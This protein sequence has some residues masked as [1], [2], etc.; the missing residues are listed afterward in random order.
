MAHSDEF[1]VFAHRGAGQVGRAPHRV[2][3]VFAPVIPQADLVLALRHCDDADL[4]AAKMPADADTP[5]YALVATYGAGGGDGQVAVFARGPV[6]IEADGPTGEVAFSVEAQR[7]AAYALPLDCT[8]LSVRRVG[9]AT[10]APEDCLALDRD[11]VVSGGGVTVSRLAPAPATDDVA[12]PEVV[13]E[14]V[15]D[16]AETGI[17]FAGSTGPEP[18]TW[19]TRRDASARVTPPPMITAPLE[20]PA[21]GG[22]PASPG[23]LVVDTGH[24][25]ELDSSWVIGREPQVDVAVQTHRA[26]AMRLSDPYRHVSRVHAQ[27]DVVDGDGVR[28]VVLTDRS[29]ANG[30]FVEP[31]GTTGWVQ[32]QPNVTS[33][34][35]VGSRFRIG[36]YTFRYEAG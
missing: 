20:T 12:T 5:P 25:C 14:P 33:E 35:V 16:T 2:V 4:D 9:A 19:A 24:S 30:T 10:P 3:V 22:A 13:V 31:P 23:R 26:R 34:L 27:V 11:G 1:N 17:L 15:V 36:E 28:R 32:L 29:S 6:E 8:T 21:D 7:N 18:V